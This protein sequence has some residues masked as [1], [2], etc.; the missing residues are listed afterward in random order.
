MTGK[1]LRSLAETELFADLA[2][3]MVARFEQMTVTRRFGRRQQLTFL[4]G[5]A[6]AIFI[7]KSGR[8]KVSY[9]SEEGREFIVMILG[10]GQ[11]YS[12]HSEALATALADTEVWLFSMPNFQRILASDPRIPLRLIRILGRILRRTNNAIRNL[13]FRKVS[14]R[15]INFLL[16]QEAEASGREKN[17]TTF[18]LELTHEE[19]AALIG[20]SRQTVTS[21]LHQ[22]AQEG[23]IALDHRRVTLLDPQSLKATLE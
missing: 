5:E 6:D 3:E 2:P 11:I 20:S 7:L 1:Q 22:L 19:I 9:L 4:A 18:E 14:S 8:V 13:A 23:L 21:L 16:E 17:S 15:L 12:R 10:P